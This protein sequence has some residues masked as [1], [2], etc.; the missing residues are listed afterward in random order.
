MELSTFKRL[1]KLPL[2]AGIMLS[3]QSVFA[4]TLT[5]VSVTPADN[6]AGQPSN[7]TFSYTLAQDVGADE[8]LFYVTFPSDFVVDSFG[9]ACDKL[10][11]LTLTPSPGAAICRAAYG[12]G[13]TVGF[14]VNTM[15][16]GGVDVPA[17]TVVEVVIS[18][19]TNPSVG[20]NYNFDSGSSTALMTTEPIDAMV[21]GPVIP[22]DV[23]PLQMV[24][25][26]TPGSSSSASS[27][28]SSSSSSTASSSGAL[29][30]GTCG[31]AHTGTFAMDPPPE[32]LCNTGNPASYSANATNY[33]WDCEGENGGNPASCSASLGFLITP[34][35][36]AGGTFACAPALVPYG[37]STTCTA[38]PNAGYD[39][40]GWGA[41][42]CNGVVTLACVLN[43]VV[44]SPV[45]DAQFS[46]SPTFTVTVNTSGSGT[47]SCTPN[48]VNSGSNATCTASANT[49]N[50]FAG[51][52]GDCTGGS[53]SLTNVTSNKTVTANF[54]T[55]TYNI[56]GTAAPVAG[57]S[58]SCGG[59]VSHGSSG[60]CTATA[61]TG[62]TFTSWNGCPSAS[63]NT[64]SF[65]NVTSNQNVTANFTAITYTVSGTASPAD[66]G[67]VTCTSPVNHAESASC[68]AIAAASYRLKEWSGAC[69][70]TSC[71]IASV[72]ANS[73]VTA[74]FEKIPTYNVSTSVSPAGS[75]TIACTKDVLEGGTATCTAK[76]KAG[77]RFASW[78]GD[79][80]G[81]EISCTMPNLT[82]NKSVSAIFEQTTSFTITAT[83]I[84]VAGSAVDLPVFN[85][86]K[87]SIEDA[88]V[89]SNNPVVMGTTVSCKFKPGLS[90]Q[91]GTTLRGWGGECTRVEGDRCII[92]NMS[93]DKRI[94]VH[95]GILIN[96]YLTVNPV[97][98]GSLWCNINLIYLSAM[99]SYLPVVNENCKAIPNSGYEF[100][101]FTEPPSCVG[102]MC[103]I[104]VVNFKKLSDKPVVICESCNTSSTETDDS[105]TITTGKTSE[106]D[107]N[108]NSNQSTVATTTNTGT[109]GST[110]SAKVNTQNVTGQTQAG[111]A[112]TTN[113]S[114]AG[115]TVAENNTVTGTI[116]NPTTG[117]STVVDIT[118]QGVTATVTQSDTPTSTINTGAG[119]TAAINI[120]ATGT[121]FAV[122][123]ATG[124]T[125][126]TTTVAGDTTTTTTSSG[127]TQAIN[128]ATT[129]T[130]GAGT[131]ISSSKI[132]NSTVSNSASGSAQVVTTIAAPIA[133]GQPVSL[134]SGA[135]GG[136]FVG[137]SGG[138]FAPS[139]GGSGG[140]APSSGAS[141][142]NL[143]CCRSRDSA[144]VKPG[145]RKAAA[146]EDNNQAL[147]DISGDQLQSVQ[148]YSDS[149]G[150]VEFFKP[151]TDAASPQM[152][153][154]ESTDKSFSITLSYPAQN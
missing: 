117:Q 16:G 78:D 66:A 116:N 118:N 101:S 76:A 103:P 123:N 59:S 33:T 129:T 115:F 138:G 56:S 62:Y 144:I 130:Y 128:A 92:E 132:G 46:A 77:Y 10:V 139:G 72:T 49:G 104:V 43:N 2:I 51:W 7:Y 31:I 57:G 85:T 37:N 22:K 15:I 136:G 26:G 152:T 154:F 91:N 38:A 88:L 97:G 19:I 71:S 21:P 133:S 96:R 55:A 50:N 79:C 47:A 127:T 108:G 81:T 36:T 141:S 60:S 83:K 145:Q 39:F 3:A 70:G 120:T 54:S 6:S 122:T 44:A 65:S 131:V 140:F 82:S 100:E 134:I 58:V 90:L 20:G 143:S 149:T 121:T 1:G 69:T 48:P 99:D 30:N 113:N 93:T 11:S 23:A 4:G 135:I 41:G 13:N 42:N 114:T 34:P 142:V 94:T 61:N 12:S 73:T 110:T 40:D 32:T 98:A 146:V 125:L 112:V 80:A 75:G 126:G 17:N 67:T 109:G 64:C 45:L 9:T 95:T 102:A 150:L 86:D 68:T 25:I 53:C 153:A 74:N 14:A 63:A 111:G 35:V 137:I 124:T 105:T 106:P 29:V 8:A 151:G 84:P 87:I 119:Q 27:V 52:T 24:T 148:L 18:G 89:C 28:S 147:I 107:T 5:G